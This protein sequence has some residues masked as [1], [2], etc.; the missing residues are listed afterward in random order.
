MSHK[1]VTPLVPAP[2]TDP[3]DPWSQAYKEF[4]AIAILAGVL[5][6]FL[7]LAKLTGNV[8]IDKFVTMSTIGWIVIP[9]I[10]AGWYVLGQLF[11]RHHKLAVPIGFGVIGLSVVSGL[12][13][14][15]IILL[16]ICGY[17]LY[18]IYRVQKK[19]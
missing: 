12:I 19:N 11:K 3:K 14:F 13:N 10:V 15:N 9:V 4:N 5:Y 8:D 18:V 6:C 7:L 2:S 16:L 1:K 17:Y